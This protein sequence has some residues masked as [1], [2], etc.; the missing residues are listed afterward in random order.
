MDVHQA[1]VV[2]CLLVVL[3]NGKVKKVIRTFGTTTRELL[4]LRD[5]LLSEGC[6]HVAMESTGV[7]WK[8][9]YALLEGS[10]ENSKS[11]SPTHNRLGRCRVARPMSRMRSGSPTCCAMGCC[12]PASFRPSPS[13][14]CAICCAIVASWWKVKRG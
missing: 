13:E 10:F 1:T 4:T 11:W 7:Y 5:W 3:K 9:V 12:V 2:A 14:N 8:P 6:T